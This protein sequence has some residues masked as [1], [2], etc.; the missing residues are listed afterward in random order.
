MIKSTKSSLKFSNTNKLLQVQDFITQYKSIICQFV[1]LLW[2]EPK[3]PKLLTKELTSKINTNLSARIIQCAGKQA[4]GIVRG[5]RTKQKKRLWKINDFIKHN[6]LK[7]ARKLQKIYDETKVSK[8]NINNV[9]PELDP[10]FIK[11][12]LDNTTSF[13]GWITI[14]SLGNHTKLVLPF[15]R[16]KHF[17]ALSKK[18]VLK[19]GIRLSNKKITFMFDIPEPI[20]KDKGK[21]IGIDVGQTTTISC[22]NSFTSSPNKD[23]Y[24]LDKINDILSRR[25]K[26]SKGFQKAQSHRTNYINWSINQLNLNG[27]SRVNIERIRNLRKGKRSSRKLSHWTYKNIFDKVKSYC[28]EHGV[29]VH[30]VSPTYTS[31]RCSKCGW[32]RKTNRKGKQFKCGK[33]GFAADA[34]LNAS[35]NISLPLAAISRQQ[36]LKQINRKGFYWNVLGQECIVPDVKKTD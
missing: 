35:V 7:K 8:P 22:S 17:N 19:Q 20:K 29:H 30:E 18:G 13:D 15:K 10:R 9:E 16:T 28:C 36:R 4:S 33:C 5:T 3:I 1:D 23:G 11:I 26:G 27:I 34:D 25:K 31:Q 32:T 12:D 6:F 24:D 21:T 2:N 14:T